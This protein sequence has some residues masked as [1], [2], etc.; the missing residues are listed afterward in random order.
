MKETT[1]DA[2]IKA[3]VNPEAQEIIP[4]PARADAFITP[5]SDP[6]EERTIISLEDA[7]NMA[8]KDMMKQRKKRKTT[9]SSK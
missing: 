9:S 1:H 8:R 4:Q 2:F 3:T 7:A 5:S 6:E